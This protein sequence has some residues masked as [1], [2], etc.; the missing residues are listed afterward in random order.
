MERTL[1]FPRNLRHGLG[2][3]MEQ[4]LQ[5]LLA[6]FIRAKYAARTAKEPLLRDVNIELE[7]LRFQPAP[8]HC[9]QGAAG[10]QS[11]PRPG[12]PA[13]GGPA[14][15]RLAEGPGA[16]RETT[17]PSRMIRYGDL[18]DSFVAW[19]NLLLAAKK[20]RRGKRHRP[21][22]QRFDFH[23]E[24]SLLR[25]QGELHEGSYQPGPFTTH[26]IKHPKPRLIS[27][28]PYRDRV[29]HH[30]LMNILEPILERHFHP[31]SYACRKGKGTHAASRRL[32]HLLGQ[33]RFSLQCDIRKFFPSIDH[34]LL[35]NLFRSR[36][37]D[38]RLLGVMDRIVD[39][40]NVQEA[41]SDWFPG[42]D[43]FTPWERRRGLPIGNLT[44]Q[45]FANW[46]LDELDHTVTARWGLGG[47]VRYC[48]D[49]VLLHKDRQ[50]LAD[51][52][53]ALAVWLGGR[54]L[55]LHHERL[56]IQ[57]ATN[58]RT[59]VGFRSWRTHRLLRAANVGAFRRRLRW[60]RRAYALGLIAIRQ[61]LPRLRSW[62]GHAGQANTF[63][64]VVRLTRGWVF[65]RH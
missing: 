55:R 9:P 7:V 51:A 13:Q 24:W 58:G 41:V 60:L 47:Y 40:S 30:A 2:L 44:S 14:G 27:A 4:R 8:G 61:I 25:L 53:T 50:R 19:D 63:H 3:A 52:A 5:E 26:W 28:A 49:F 38:T 16:C 56:A 39:S 59:F 33:N 54:R 43:L 22:V 6:L 34:V 32:Q 11:A 65:R 1:K 37:K 62:L 29:V 42:D 17:E 12:A 57:P 15:R 48:D 45:W 10:K 46:Y 31:H 21:V 20:A 64:L 23:L 18:W 36:L 35:K